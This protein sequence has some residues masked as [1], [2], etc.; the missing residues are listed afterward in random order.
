[1]WRPLERSYRSSRDCGSDLGF[2]LAVDLRSIEGEGGESMKGTLILSAAVF[3][4]ALGGCGADSRPID[5]QDRQL[6]GVRRPART[7]S[8]DLP[9]DSDSDDAA[10]DEPAEPTKVE[11]LTTLAP[12]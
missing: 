2:T 4:L 8:A 5:Q 7:F 9:S 12:D 3:G 6:Q 10:N 11:Q 1:V